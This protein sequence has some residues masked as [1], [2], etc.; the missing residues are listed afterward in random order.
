MEAEDNQTLLY[1]GTD[2]DGDQIQIVGLNG[3]DVILRVKNTDE[4]L[5]CGVLLDSEMMISIISTLM[6]A[7]I[8]LNLLTPDEE[9]A[10]Q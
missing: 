2:R 4:K 1:L 6:A 10:V 3:G 8:L 9:E 7:R 5:S